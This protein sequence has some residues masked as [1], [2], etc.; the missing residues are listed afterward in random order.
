MATAVNNPSAEPI[1]NTD[2]SQEDLSQLNG[3]ASIEDE[4]TETEEPPA[5]DTP[6]SPPSPNPSQQKTSPQIESPERPKGPSRPSIKVQSNSQQSGWFHPTVHSASKSLFRLFRSPSSTSINTLPVALGPDGSRASI[7]DSL[8]DGFDASGN[9]LSPKDARVVIG[10]IDGV[11]TAAER[12]QAA[13]KEMAAASADLG[14]A[15]D[16]LSKSNGLESVSSG[17]S[18]AGGLQLL[19]SNHAQLLAASVGER[20]VE[21]SRRELD[22]YKEDLKTREQSFQSE[23]RHRTTSLRKAETLTQRQSRSRNR[24]LAA[25]RSTLLDLTSQIDDINRLKYDF[26]SDLYISA[27]DLGEQ[28][29]RSAASMVTAEIEIYDSIARKGW[30]GNGLDDLIAG[31]PDPF[32][33]IDN[34]EEEPDHPVAINVATSQSPD[35]GSSGRPVGSNSPP[36]NLFSVLPPTS[37]LPKQDHED[38]DLQDVDRRL[39][40]FR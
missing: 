40:L 12:F 38:D 1:E 24:N 8:C 3:K 35:F 5:D 9:L 33:S 19:V 17:I 29:E 37:I 21:P 39:S 15:L 20:F 31:C 18:A 25:Y 22:N 23:L 30:S 4:R 36:N 32:E 13:I 14:T 11:A 10:K 34:D 2:H 6:P 27:S 7:T 16:D 28:I 26:L